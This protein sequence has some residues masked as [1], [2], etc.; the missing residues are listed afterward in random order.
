MKPVV[1]KQRNITPI[2][3]KAPLRLQDQSAEDLE[4]WLKQPV[5]FRLRAVTFL[6][7]QSLKKQEKMDK[8][9]VNKR[10]R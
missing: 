8:S 10:K 4:Y 6:V 3:V 7:S 2:V 9:I 1:I 5:I